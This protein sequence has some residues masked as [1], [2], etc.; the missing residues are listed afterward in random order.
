M[1]RSR[2]GLTTKIHALV[3]ACGLPILLKI[4][5]GQ[6]HDGRSAYDMLGSLGRVDEAA[7]AFSQGFRLQPDDADAHYNFG[8]ALA[9]AGRMEGAAREF[10]AIVRLRPGVAGPLFGVAA[11]ELTNRFV[12]LEDIW[13]LEGSRICERLL[14][15]HGAAEAVA[16]LQRV[17]FVRSMRESVST[18]VMTAIFPKAR[19]F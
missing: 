6:A 19:A 8:I 4:T 3:D 11:S 16:E 18:F 5:E 14:A 2:G 9:Q 1:G 10:R 13:G 15:A 7:T 17:L 12:L